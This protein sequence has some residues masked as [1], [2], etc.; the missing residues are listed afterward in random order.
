M[1]REDAGPGSWRM[2]EEADR[3]SC[4]EERE[5]RGRRG[6]GEGVKEAGR[7]RAVELGSGIGTK[8]LLRSLDKRAMTEPRTR[9][10]LAS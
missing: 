10:P 7:R 9:I 1:G 8:N 4:S 2:A 5:G 6:G 3:P